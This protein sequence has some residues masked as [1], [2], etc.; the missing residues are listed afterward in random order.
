MKW[1]WGKGLIVGMI[2]FMGFI[3]YFVVMMSSDKK[4]HHDIVTQ[5]YYAKE[6]AYQ[7]EID[8]QENVLQLSGGI[9]GRR[10]EKG[11]MLH[12]P[13]EIQQHNTKGTIFLYRPSNKRL[14]TEFPMALTSSNLLIPDDKLVDGR[15]DIIVQW[16]TDGKAYLYKTSIFY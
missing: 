7:T 9:Q 1:H 14:D 15:W 13:K 8:Q 10:H 16:Q 2:A 12:F 11:W 4:F 6:M 3:M 5:D